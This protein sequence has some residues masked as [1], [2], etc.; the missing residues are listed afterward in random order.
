MSMSWICLE[1]VLNMSW[2]CLEY[3]LNIAWISPEYLLNG[4]I[5]RSTYKSNNFWTPAYFKTIFKQQVDIH[6]VYIRL[7]F[8]ANPLKNELD[9]SNRSERPFRAVYISYS[10]KNESIFVEYLLNALLFFNSFF[11]RP[12]HTSI[13]HGLWVSCKYNKKMTSYRQSN[14]VYMRK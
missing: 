4:W 12:R 6:F 7:K 14:K 8:H 5:F 9:T 1:Y 11:M 10:H 13:L 2:I 3:R